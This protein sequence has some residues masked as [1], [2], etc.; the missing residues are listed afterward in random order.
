MTPLQLCSVAL[1]LFT[2][3]IW[4][5][6]IRSSSIRLKL[7]AIVGNL[8]SRVS[9]L[10]RFH[11]WVTDLAILNG[12]TFR[13]D[14]PWKAR[15]L[16][17]NP[18]NIEYVLRTRYHN[19]GK[20]DSFKDI[21]RDLFGDSIFVSE[22]ERFAQLNKSV[23]M[24]VASAAFRSTAAVAVPAAVHQKLLPLLR[25]ACEK[26]TV[27]DLQD[28]FL[29]LAF[30]IVCVVGFGEDPAS[31]SPDL[32]PIP[33]LE[34]YESAVKVSMYRTL[35]P[36]LIWKAMRF[37]NLGEERRLR[38][39]LQIVY[40]Y[41]DGVLARRKFDDGSHG[42]G[43]F[44]DIVSAFLHFERENGRHHSYRSL[45]SLFVNQILAG[46][47]TVSVG[48]T[49]FFWVLARHPESEAQILAEI[50]DIV[51]QRADP[52]S[53]DEY[54]PSPFSLEEVK[55]MHYL[56]A[57]LSESLRLYPPI[58]NEIT[59]A[60]Q[61]DVLPDGTAVKKGTQLVY[62]IYATGRL[63][64]VWGKDC[65]E[66]KPERWLKNGRFVRESDFK[67]PVFNGGPRRCTGREFAYWQ[68]K[69]VA[70]SVVVRYGVKIVDPRQPVPKF[71]MALAMRHG[72][73]AT[74]HRRGKES[75]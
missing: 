69:W 67:F 64:N 29:R 31:L 20:G 57:A 46:T 26:P 60:A 1:A 15:V 75:E 27:V 12:G 24:A 22:G 10:R 66:F 2:F 71:T 63:E 55:E 56:H 68:M 19:F 44:S 6:G 9:D 61:D 51:K 59:E 8:P 21:F 53:R 49:W 62:L 4:L 40:G 34:A 65:R 35:M 33:F 73:L 36:P 47:E 28:V 13:L 45:P 54:D 14:T 70:A 50:R 17:A 32:P 25:Q 48:L 11:D 23:A 52:E 43:Q 7:L 30:D 39:D 16:T 3:F 37:F 58:P 74:L 18:D 42:A 5:H 38:R 72:L 41:M